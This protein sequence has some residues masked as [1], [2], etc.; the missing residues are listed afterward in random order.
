MKGRTRDH[1]DELSRE[2]AA[3]L[4]LLDRVERLERLER[5][6]DQLEAAADPSAAPPQPDVKP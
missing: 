6:V 3:I 5:R 1:D 4:S 2:Q